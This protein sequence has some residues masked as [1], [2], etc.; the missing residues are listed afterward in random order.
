MHTK[1]KHNLSEF[2][3][4]FTNIVARWPGST[5]DSFVFNNSHIG[6][7]LESQPHSVEDGLLLGDSGYPC[8]PYLMTPYL[9][10]TTAKQETYNKAHTGTRLAIEQAFGWWKR[11]F[12]LLHSEVRM[13]PE[14]T[15]QLIGACAVLHNIALLQNE[16]IHGLL[17]N[18][19]QPDI[20]PYHG[21]ENG[22]A[23]RDY[24][25]NTFF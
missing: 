6:Q 20:A 21:P 1:A 4:M 15:C 19:D 7:K 2:L 14:K 22:K 16:P 12:H 25:C 24:I 13:N 9:N 5:H 23:V 8:K 17:Q 18:E 10:P 11:R 3:G